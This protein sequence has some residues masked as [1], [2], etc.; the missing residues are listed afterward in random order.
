MEI[1]LDAARRHLA[2]G[3]DTPLHRSGQ[4]VGLLAPLLILGAG[5]A[6]SHAPS[7]GRLVL[8]SALALLG[9]YAMR[10]SVVSAGKKSAEDAESYWHATS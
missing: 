1:Q 7:R 5:L 10:A 9:G 3:P 8:A 6:R 2:S 4:I